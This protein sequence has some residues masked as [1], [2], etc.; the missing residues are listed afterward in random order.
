MPDTTV[1][2]PRSLLDE[3]ASYL[4][5]EWL[6]KVKVSNGNLW[7]VV[8]G[9]LLDAI[10]QGAEDHKAKLRYHDDGDGFFEYKGT[11]DVNLMASKIAWHVVAKL[12]SE[13]TVAAF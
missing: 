7:C 1:Q 12:R 6:L 10:S 8:H 2:I 13:A 3:T 11:L 5:E 4:D 9:A